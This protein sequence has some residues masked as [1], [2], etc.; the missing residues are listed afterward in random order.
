MSLSEDKEWGQAGI[1]FLFLVNSVLILHEKK[2][3]SQAWQPAMNIR[4]VCHIL[5][6]MN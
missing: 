3:V 2:N 4:L 6:I 1:I 5:N